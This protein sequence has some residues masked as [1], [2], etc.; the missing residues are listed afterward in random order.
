[1]KAHH[2]ICIVLSFC[3]IMFSCSKRGDT[4]EQLIGKW[5]LDSIQV[6]MPDA[7]N[8]PKVVTIYSSS[9]DYYDFRDDLR[10]Y[11]FFKSRYDTIP[12]TLEKN[13]SGAWLIRYGTPTSADTIQSLS[14]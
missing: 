1:M 12:Y 14:K 2:F 3:F 6:W 5:R 13:G 7:N 10:L 9:T 8:I 11:R 4:N